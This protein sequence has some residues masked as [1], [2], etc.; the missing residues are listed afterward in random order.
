MKMKY[1]NFSEEFAEKILDGEK[2]A[3]LRLGIKD[4]KAGESVI[5]KAGDKNLGIARIS[6]VRMIKFKDLSK[7]DAIMDG[8]GSVEEL[9]K[10]L[11]KFYGKIDPEDI[12][13]QIIFELVRQ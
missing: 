3:T 13:T 5:V 11:E 4:Y 1:L 9:K 6:A 7:K 8:F 12:F 2:I 10:T